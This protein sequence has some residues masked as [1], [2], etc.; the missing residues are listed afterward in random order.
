VRAA[1]RHNKRSFRW[2]LLDLAA[3]M[4]RSKF[5]QWRNPVRWPSNHEVKLTRIPGESINPM[6]PSDTSTVSCVFQTQLAPST[7]SNHRRQG[8]AGFSA[9][10]QDQAG[11]SAGKLR[12]R[13]IASN[14]RTSSIGLNNTTIAS[15]FST[16][17]RVISSLRP[18]INIVG[19]GW[20]ITANL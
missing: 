1:L 20:P 13:E 4:P 15:D 9:R 16:S 3:G 14:R 6:A 17:R 11:F 12:H 7:G 19:S 2:A 10:P 8:V 18:V 5:S